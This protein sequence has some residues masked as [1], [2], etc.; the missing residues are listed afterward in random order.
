MCYQMYSSTSF[1]R[2]SSSGIPQASTYTWLDLPTGILPRINKGLGSLM[3]ISRPSHLA[4]L[5]I[6]F[7]T[8]LDLH[9]SNVSCCKYIRSAVVIQPQTVDHLLIRI[10]TPGENVRTILESSPDSVVQE[11]QLREILGI[12]WLWGLWAKQLSR[13]TW[14]GQRKTSLSLPC[15]PVTVTGKALDLSVTGELPGD[16]CTYPWIHDQPDLA[17]V[18]IVWIFDTE[19]SCMETYDSLC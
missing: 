4:K 13:R 14:T 6:N 9:Y 17:S 10:A 8:V 18:C 3:K 19:K 11:N 15:H 16:Q 2:S 7:G 5:T 12:R 1:D